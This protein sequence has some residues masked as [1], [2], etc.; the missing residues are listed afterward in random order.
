MNVTK[1]RYSDAIHAGG[2]AQVIGLDVSRV[3]IGLAADL[4]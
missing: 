3:A 1:S 2:Q 4:S